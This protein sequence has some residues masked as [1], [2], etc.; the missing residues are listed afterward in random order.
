MNDIINI[1][2]QVR[3]VSQKIKEQRKE[4]FERGES[5]NIF[6]DL[7]FMSDEVHLHSMFLAN[8]LNPTL[9]PQHYSLTLFISA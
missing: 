7:G 1:L 5:F 4:K 9:I 6:N 2:N 3:I 8:L